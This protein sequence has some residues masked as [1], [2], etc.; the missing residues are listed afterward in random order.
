MITQHAIY[1]VGINA[2]WR[3]STINALDD[4]LKDWLLDRESLTKRL[5][6]SC[7]NFRVQVLGQRLTTCQAYE[8]N[9][10]I[11]EGEP[12]VAREVLLFCDE[13]P[14]VF[15]R[16]LLPVRSLTGEQ[17]EL[18]QLGNESM[19]QVLF[20]HPDLKRKCIEVASFDG[21]AHFSS[22]LS[23]FGLDCQQQLWGRRSVFLIDE[24]PLMVAEVFL[25]DA[26]AYENVK[27]Y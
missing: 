15:A 9:D 17:A 27:V 16:S 13:T 19:G 25:P 5:V 14:H 23:T 26:I 4:N 22:I 3:P 18:A 10:D 8:A 11:L 24:K 2:N 7:D 6:S 21:Q 20:N 1:P 12:V